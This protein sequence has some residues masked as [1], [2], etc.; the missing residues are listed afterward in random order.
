MLRRSSCPS[1]ARDEPAHRSARPAGRFVHLELRGPEGRLGVAIGPAT[2]GETRPERLDRVLKPGVNRGRCPDVLQ[3]PER[4]AGGE[5]APDLGESAR[6][7]RDGAEDEARDDRVEGTG[8]ERESFGRTE[9][10]GDPGSPPTGRPEG[11]DARIETERVD[12]AFE[13][14]QVPAR[15]APEVHDPPSRAGREPAPPASEAGC[16]EESEAGIVEGR[17]LLDA[18]H[19][20]VSFWNTPRSRFFRTSSQGKTIPFMAT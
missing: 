9:N 12:A 11:L 7:L 19:A 6:G 2:A 10:D 13:E 14:G 17:N 5:D 4:A 20:H 3:H 1:G 15:S 8:A 18:P 16:L